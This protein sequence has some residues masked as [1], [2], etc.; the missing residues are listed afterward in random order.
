MIVGGQ[1]LLE[2]R[3]FEQFGVRVDDPAR[4]CG[5]QCQ[6][7]MIIEPLRELV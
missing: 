4:M 7:I 2:L 5:P 3:R 1:G 6:P